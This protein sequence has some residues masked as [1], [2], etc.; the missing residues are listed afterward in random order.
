MALSQGRCEVGPSPKAPERTKAVLKAVK[1]TLWLKSLG[2]KAGRHENPKNNNN[3]KNSEV[4]FT[5]W[6]AVD[7]QER[8]S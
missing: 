5:R 1:A 7:F 6:S 4:K 2:M 8:A 3:A